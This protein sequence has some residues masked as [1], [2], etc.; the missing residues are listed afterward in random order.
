MSSSRK[1]SSAQ[2]LIIV[3]IILIALCVLL[4]GAVFYFPTLASPQEENGPFPAQ[5]EEVP[6]AEPL[7]SAPENSP[8][9]V[10]KETQPRPQASATTDQIILPQGLE[11]PLCA[12]SRQ[13]EDHQ[14][15]SF[16]DYEIC[17]RE[18]YE[19][20]EWASY[21]LESS[22]LVKNAGRSDNFRSD[23]QITTGSASPADYRSSGYDRGHLAPA[24]DFSYSSEAMSST[25]Y[26]SNMTAQFPQFNR[27][28]WKSLEEQVRIWAK[29]YGRVYVICGPVFDSPAS[30]YE[31]IGANKVAI[32]RYFYKV[33]L[34]PVYKDA[35]DAQTPDS[36]ASLKAY[37]YIIPNEKCE[38]PFS[39]YSCSVDEIEER[40]GID[41]F[42]LLEDE[43]EN[44][45]ESQR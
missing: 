12:A 13:T 44:A 18:S 37:S 20:A 9:P 14:I 22:E 3:F 38:Q 24:A 6:S 28:I 30:D 17:Y 8:Y 39:A 40:T 25:F 31:T 27:G 4:L 33:V 34:A 11:Y 45:V 23:P 36:C 35:E 21:L 7:P 19:S 26:M 10:Q 15:R 1:K 5:S 16:G 2:P 41:F 43:I 32:P 29:E 42:Y